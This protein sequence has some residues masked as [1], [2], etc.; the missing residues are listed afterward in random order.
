MTQPAEIDR[1]FATSLARGLTRLTFALR[2]EAEQV[3]TLPR[4]L[5]A[6]L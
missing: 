1:F 5:T 3:S 2:C 6:A 4:L